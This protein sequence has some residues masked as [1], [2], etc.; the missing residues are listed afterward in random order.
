MKP[1]NYSKKTMNRMIRIGTIAI[2]LFIPIVVAGQKQ[3]IEIVPNLEKYN[4]GFVPG[5]FFIEID[6][7]VMNRVYLSNSGDYQSI[8]DLRIIN[9]YWQSA[10]I[11]RRTL[12]LYRL[13]QHESSSEQMLFS[14]AVYGE[15]GINNY[16]GIGISLNGADLNRTFIL[17]YSLTNLQLGHFL[18][19][20]YGFLPPD[21]PLD[22][23]D[24]AALAQKD[25]HYHIY[26]TTFNISIHPWKGTLDPFLRFGIGPAFAEWN[27]QGFMH[28][29]GDIGFRFFIY[30]GW[31]ASIS[32]HGET[33]EAVLP[34]NSPFI[35]GHYS[36]VIHN[37]GLH[38]SIG[39][40][41]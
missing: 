8:E 19:Y 22:I 25:A 16:M 23:F 38:L 17:P 37:D 3:T 31:F 34:V 30:D 6:Y 29:T 9:A 24:A 10:N 20:G 28:T 41:I 1:V 18:V 39:K 7:Q 5:K 40:K 15:Y 12:A 32:Y 2:I 21:R 14:G 35:T 36:T 13:S 11:D 33:Y 4:R 26:S 27:G